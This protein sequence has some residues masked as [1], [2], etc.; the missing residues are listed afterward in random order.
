MRIRRAAI[1]WSAVFALVCC[2]SASAQTPPPIQGAT[3][4]TPAMNVS[5]TLNQL[6]RPV[7]AP[8]VG[9]ALGLAT[10]LAIGT[11]PFGASSGGFL[12]KLD[13]STG[14]QVR[15]ATTFGPAFAERALTNGE[16]KV[17]VGVNFASVTYDRLDKLAFD[18]LQLRSAAGTSPPAQARS[19]IANLSLTSKTIVVAGR[20]GVTDKFDIGVTVPITT[21]QVDGTTSLRDANGNMTLFAQGSNVSKGLGDI[22]GLAKYR[23]LSFGSGQPDPGGLAAMVTMRLPTGDQKNLRGLGV[24]RTLVSF[25]ASSGQGRFRPHANVGYGWWSKGVSVVSDSAPNTSVTA[26]HQ[27]EYAAGLELEAAP[28][29]TLLVDVLGGSI[30]DGG[31]LGMAAVTSGATSYQAL[32]ALREGIR[33][34]DLAPGLKV[35]L[36]GKLLLSLNAL[37]AL[38]DSGLHARVTP[39][40]GIDLN[41]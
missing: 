40:A 26:R 30:F 8:H 12:I 33:R 20:M 6:V 36:K 19:G 1:G 9:D 3:T 16:G 32:V 37:V 15:T 31:R 14:L 7:G 2:G 5:D 41:F 23:F 39:V 11:A 35:N 18:G 34:V 4:T 10:E 27:F 21:V 38:Q 28:K 24:T 17:S 25:I 22:A 13:P 29:L